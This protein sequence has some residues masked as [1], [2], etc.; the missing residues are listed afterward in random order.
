MQLSKAVDSVEWRCSRRVCKHQYIVKKE[1][2]ELFKQLHW[3]LRASLFSEK[4]KK[5]IYK[6]CFI[7]GFKYWRMGEVIN[8]KPMTEEEADKLARKEHFLGEVV[9]D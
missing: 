3:A 5:C 4:Y 2:P 6:V 8:R 9:L 1:Q 7:A